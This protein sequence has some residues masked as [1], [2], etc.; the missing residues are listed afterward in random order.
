MNDLRPMDLVSE[1]ERY[2][3][4]VQVFREQGCEPHWRR[5]PSTQRFDDHR[6]PGRGSRSSERRKK[7]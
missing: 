6:L 1:A 2:L 7:C 3:A 4:L 5:E